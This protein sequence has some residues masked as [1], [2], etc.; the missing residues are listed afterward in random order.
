MA[1]RLMENGVHSVSDLLLMDQERIASIIGS[2]RTEKVLQALS[3]FRNQSSHP[4]GADSEE[5][6]NEPEDSGP[7]SGKTEFRRKGQQ[8]IID[9]T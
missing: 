3:E 8:S 5:N 4:A 9:F 1:E 7:Q 2:G 6:E